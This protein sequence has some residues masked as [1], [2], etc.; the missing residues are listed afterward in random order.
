MKW[1]FKKDKGFLD[2]RENQSVIYM[3]HGC[4][5]GEISSF[6]ASDAK[7]SE[8]ILEQGHKRT[9]HKREWERESK[10]NNGR[11]ARQI[12]DTQTKED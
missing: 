11:S 5:Q 4:I 8:K 7:F 6:V 12:L 3:F 1:N 2:I 10:S 9:L